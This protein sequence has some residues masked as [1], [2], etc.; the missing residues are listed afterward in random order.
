VWKS[1]EALEKQFSPSQHKLAKIPDAVKLNAN[2]E[3]I[4]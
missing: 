4:I 1:I 2:S 3:E